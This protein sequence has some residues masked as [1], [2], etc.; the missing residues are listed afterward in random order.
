MPPKPKAK[1]V[2]IH[3]RAARADKLRIERA[4]RL[5]SV[6]ASEWIRRVVIG[7]VGEGD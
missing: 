1:V 3:F 6:P 2:T 7:A 4:A 5:A